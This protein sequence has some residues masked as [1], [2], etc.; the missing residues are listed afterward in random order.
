MNNIVVL[1]ATYNGEK[2]LKEQIDSLIDQSESFDLIIRDDGSKDSTKDIILEY[3]DSYENIYFLEDDKN[4]TSAKENFSILLEYALT[5]ENYDYFMFCDQDD[6]WHK[7]KIAISLAKMKETE[8]NTKGIPILVHSDL[9][10]VDEDLNILSSSYWKYQNI[11]PSKDS[12]NRLLLQNVVTGCTMMINKDLAKLSLPIAQNAIMHDWWVS[13]IASAIGQV[14]RVDKPLVKYRQ[15]SDNDTG[16]KSFFGEYLLNR[17]NRLFSIDMSK[18][19]IQA[20]K[21]FEI[22]EDRLNYEQKDLLYS[23][24]KLNSYSYLQ[25]CYILIKFKIYKIGILRNLGL[26]LKI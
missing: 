26:F 24:S 11:D 5:I 8:T 2:Y 1:L 19:I 16:A 3:V 6:I 23:F 17:I 15:H 18:Y 21:L 10:V 25:R 22:L 13:L 7:N 12:L 9:E 4:S 14:I 20:K